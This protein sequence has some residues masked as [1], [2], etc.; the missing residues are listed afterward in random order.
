MSRLTSSFRS[1]KV[2]DMTTETYLNVSLEALN[3][4][5]LAEAIDIERERRLDMF[6]IYPVLDDL[7]VLAEDGF[8]YD[9][10]RGGEPKRVTYWCPQ[11]VGW[12]GVSHVKKTVR[13]ELTDSGYQVEQIEDYGS[14]CEMDWLTG[15]IGSAW[16]GHAYRCACLRC[17]VAEERRG[18]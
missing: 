11:C 17:S 3:A 13:R 18:R 6:E 4:A 8:D 14:S 5:S 10:T 1:P 16:S 7:D 15:V 12:Y 9:R 2:D